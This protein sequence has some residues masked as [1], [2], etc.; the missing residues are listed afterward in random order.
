MGNI[1]QSNSHQLV[2]NAGDDQLNLLANRPSIDRA[3]CNFPEVGQS[4]NPRRKSNECTVVQALG[5]N[6]FDS[7]AHSVLLDVSVKAFFVTRTLNGKTKAH[8]RSKADDTNSDLLPALVVNFFT[9]PKDLRLDDKTRLPVWQPHKK[10]IRGNTSD[11]TKNILT[12]NVFGAHSMLLCGLLISNVTIISIGW[13]STITVKPQLF[14]V[15]LLFARSHWQAK[16]WRT[17]VL[18]VTQ[19]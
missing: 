7:L 17:V 13:C 15:N 10:S 5:Y 18:L 12:N 9:G 19:H 1:G 14:L 2:M 4:L 6:A 8:A 3:L 16:R 11:S